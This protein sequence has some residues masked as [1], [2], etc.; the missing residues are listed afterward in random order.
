MDEAVG[1][2]AEAGEDAKV[3]AGGQSLVPL[4]A[5]RL[6]RP[7]HLV[8]IDRVSELAATSSGAAGRMTVGALT[9]HVWL[10]RA[11]WAGSRQLLGEAAARIGHLPVRTRGTIGGSVAHADPAAELPVALIA[12]DAVIHTYGPGGI[13]RVAATDFFTGPFTTVLQHAEL[14]TAVELPASAPSSTG[15]FEEFAVRSGDF[16]LAAAAVA[17]DVAD[18]TVRG[19][20]VAVGGVAATATRSTAAEEVLEGEAASYELVA[21][22]A[23]A[24]AAA[25]DPDVD[26]GSRRHRRAV[27]EHVVRTALSR[28]LGVAR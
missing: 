4:L 10:E 11:A 26:P 15:A 1:L 13:R 18:G 9:R 7:S 20:R 22:A 28:A 6:A 24:A 16:A 25:C 3:L 21:A 8:D 5:Y 14:V 19:A 27:L 12:L 23:A 17:C 2:L